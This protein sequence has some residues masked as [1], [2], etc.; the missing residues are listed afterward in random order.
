MIAQ[1]FLEQSQ[2]AW[3]ILGL[4]LLVLEILA[5]GTLF[6]WFGV[7]AVVV[8]IVCFFF[9]IAWQGQIILFGVLSLIAVILGRMIMARFTSVATDKPLLNERAQ[10]L[11]GRQFVLDE[12]IVNG[13]GR[14]KVNDSYWRVSGPDCEKGHKVQVTGGAGVELEVEPVAKA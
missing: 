14:V 4:L 12:P 5:P 2:W 3:L 1:F 11:V 6:L 13:R 10:A 8:G 9:D 7:S